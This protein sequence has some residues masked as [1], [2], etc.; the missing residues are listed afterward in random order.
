MT[1]KLYCTICTICYYIVLSFIVLLINRLFPL[2][3][4]LCC[5]IYS[6][7]LLSFNDIIIVKTNSARDAFIQ[8]HNVLFLLKNILKI[9]HSFLMSIVSHLYNTKNELLKLKMFCHW[10][11]TASALNW[12]FGQIIIVMF[13]RKHSFYHSTSVSVKRNIHIMYS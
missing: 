6:L 4:E 10:N 7:F 3:L 8:R 12:K 2:R 11:S 1:F 13:T 9:I 5:T